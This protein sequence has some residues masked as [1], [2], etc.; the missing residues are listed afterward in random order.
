M[1][2]LENHVTKFDLEISC[3]YANFYQLLPAEVIACRLFLSGSILLMLKGLSEHYIRELLEECIIE[4]IWAK[5]Q[6]EIQ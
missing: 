1:K 2:D 4:A 3:A 6:K 5:D